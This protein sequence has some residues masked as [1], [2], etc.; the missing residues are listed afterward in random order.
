MATMTKRKDRD[1]VGVSAK[2]VMKSHVG[3]T[4]KVGGSRS[5]VQSSEV[6]GTSNRPMSGTP[7]MRRK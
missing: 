2:S 5:G 3:P 6:S 7:N 1:V 4:G